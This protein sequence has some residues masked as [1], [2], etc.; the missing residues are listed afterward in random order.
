MDGASGGEQGSARTWS[1]RERDI[2]LAAGYDPDGTDP[3]Q[4][5]AGFLSRLP[6]T[7][8]ERIIGPLVNDDVRMNAEAIEAAALDNQMADRDLDLD[9]RAARP[10]DDLCTIPR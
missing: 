1:Q 5:D 4:F 3:L 8:V 10:G 9:R 6:H 2:L 7:H